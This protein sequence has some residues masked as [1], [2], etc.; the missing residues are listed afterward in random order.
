MIILLRF[1]LFILSPYS[2]HLS[3]DL[4]CRILIIKIFSFLEI[5]SI[6]KIVG[7]L[8]K[9]NLWQ[10]HKISKTPI[11]IGKTSIEKLIVELWKKVF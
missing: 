8:T 3:Q 9:A 2:N 7:I 11:K 1:I 6:T 4:R 5:I 10:S